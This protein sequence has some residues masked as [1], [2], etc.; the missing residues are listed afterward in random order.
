MCG[1]IN[2]KVVQLRRVEADYR[3]I[4]TIHNIEM[5]VNRIMPISGFALQQPGHRTTGDEWLYTCDEV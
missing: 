5:L 3:H 2:P 4:Y 1:V